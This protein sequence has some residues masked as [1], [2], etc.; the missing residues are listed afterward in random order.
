MMAMVM[1]MI[2]HAGLVLLLEIVLQH[3]HQR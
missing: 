2:R 3:Q 1:A